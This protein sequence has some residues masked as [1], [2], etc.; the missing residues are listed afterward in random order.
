VT[1]GTYYHT[2]DYGTESYTFLSGGVCL[3][4]AYSPQ[5][6]SMGKGFF[7]GTWRY[8][9]DGK[10]LLID[11][12]ANVMLGMLVIHVVE[13]WDSAFT[14]DDGQTLHL[15]GLKKSNADIERLADTYAGSGSSVTEISGFMNY[16]GELPNTGQ[17]TL[18]DNGTQEGF[19]VRYGN[20]DEAAITWSATD[21][22]L[23][24]FRGDYYLDADNSCFVYKKRGGARYVLQRDKFFLFE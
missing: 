19:F 1:S 18:S 17:L 22:R 23:I 10:A 9:D 2:Y 3:R 8:A 6:T 12:T 13:V 4:T 11:T 24:S 5:D 21:A 7:T 15:L 20:E 14:T 16:T